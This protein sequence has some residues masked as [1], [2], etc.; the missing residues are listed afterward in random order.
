MFSDGFST[1]SSGY[2]DSGYYGGGHYGSSSSFDDL[3]LKK[4]D[5]NSAN[6]EKFEK[7]FYYE[8][9]ESKK[10]TQKEA[11]D[12]RRNSGIKMKIG[13]FLPN[14]NMTFSSTCFRRMT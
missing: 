12:F 2:D 13:K 5:W 8:T 11:D 6:L 10:L 9:E 1:L 14:P 3:T 7:N 4:V